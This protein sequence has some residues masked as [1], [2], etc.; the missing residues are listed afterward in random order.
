MGFNLAF[1]ELNCLAVLDTFLQSLLAGH[2]AL[3]YP[4]SYTCELITFQM[5]VLVIRQYEVENDKIF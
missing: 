5:Y 2:S 3:R 4:F 1:K